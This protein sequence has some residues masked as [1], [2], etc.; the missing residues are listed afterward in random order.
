MKSVPKK[1][2]WYLRSRSCWLAAHFS[3]SVTLSGIGSAQAI[4]AFSLATLT[5]ALRSIC[6]DWTVQKRAWST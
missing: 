1:A 5:T 2:S 4:S 3:G 6:E